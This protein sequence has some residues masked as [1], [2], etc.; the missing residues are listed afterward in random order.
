MVG[1]TLF[2]I[3]LLAGCARSAESDLQYV[4]QA[5]SIAA[6]WALINE[7]AAAGKLTTTYVI[8]MHEWLRED[9]KTTASSLT[10][11][12]SPHGNEVQALMAEPADAAPGRLRAHADRLKRIEDDLESA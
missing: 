2:L 8:S 1:R 7:Q 5:R 12:H 11:P 10:D 3:A 4:K 6:E 9:L